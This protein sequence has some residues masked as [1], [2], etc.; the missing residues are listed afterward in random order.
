[1]AVASYNTDAALTDAGYTLL[2]S[3]SEAELE[4]RMVGE[5]LEVAALVLRLSRMLLQTR[6]VTAQSASS[7]GSG[8]EEAIALV[9]NSSLTSDCDSASPVFTV[10]QQQRRAA[11][12][13]S[14]IQQRLELP[15]SS[16]SS[17]GILDHRGRYWAWHANHRQSFSSLQ[18]NQ[19]DHANNDV[20][21][22]YVD[23]DKEI[24]AVAHEE[25]KRFFGV[26]ERG[27]QHAA[28][29]MH[30]LMR[31]ALDSHIDVL[32]SMAETR[33]A[34]S[35]TAGRDHVHVPTVDGARMSA[36]STSAVSAS[37]SAHA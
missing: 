34:L 13:A 26:S 2:P 23:Y 20:H 15:E 14:E 21:G 33:L 18:D 16:S 30:L 17:S 19:A 27:A 12:F 32:V 31:L 6:S 9:S 4:A 10:F 28:I 8:K 37:R 22:S 3:M 25:K 5:C 7:G 24:S 1:M 36:A 11:E 35:D 29:R